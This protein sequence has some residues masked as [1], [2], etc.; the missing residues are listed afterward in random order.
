MEK[1]YTSKKKGLGKWTLL[2]HYKGDM[3]KLK[4]V[5]FKQVKKSN[6]Y[7]ALGSNPN[8]NTLLIEQ[9]IQSLNTNA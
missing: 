8:Y 2:F 6:V 3:N 9:R 1:L 4:Q 7:L 5:E